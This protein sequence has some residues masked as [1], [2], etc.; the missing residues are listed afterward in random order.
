M[1]NTKQFNTRSLLYLKTRKDYRFELYDQAFRNDYGTSAYRFLVEGHNLLFHFGNLSDDRLLLAKSTLGC[2]AV[3]LYVDRDYFEL[4]LRIRKSCEHLTSWQSCKEW[5]SKSMLELEGY[6]ASF[7]KEYQFF[8][9]KFLKTRHR[10]L[11]HSNLKQ[12][13]RSQPLLGQLLVFLILLPTGLLAF[14]CVRFYF[15]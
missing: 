11:T 10:N 1:L 3:M 8:W 15:P 14:L 9:R 13:T 4:V 6:M 5:K 7:F 12:K 2:K